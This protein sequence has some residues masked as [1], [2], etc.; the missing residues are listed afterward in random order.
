MPRRKVVDLHQRRR[1][2]VI[3]CLSGRRCCR[4]RSL[5]LN[6]DPLL[7]LAVI[8]YLRSLVSTRLISPL[9]QGLKS[10]V[11]LW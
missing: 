5:A 7:L 10:V 2:R 4:A 1:R 11:Q 9:K 3:V 6:M 8:I